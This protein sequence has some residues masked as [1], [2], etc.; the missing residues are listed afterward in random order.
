VHQSYDRLTYNIARD[1]GLYGADI[2][3]HTLNMAI[4]GL[5]PTRLTTIGGRSG[6]GKTSLVAQM[7]DAG[8]K[9]VNGRRCE[10]LFNTWELDPSLIIDRLICN[11]AGVNLRMLNQGAK[12]LDR[13]TL[14]RINGAYR[15]AE[16][17]P[18]FYQTVSTDIK[19]VRSLALEFCKRCKE[20]SVVEG[21]EIQPVGVVDYLNM[22]MFEG[23]GL[24]TYGIGDFMNG[25][26]QL[27]NET[28]MAWV[29][30]AQIS[31][32]TD[33]ENRIPDRADFS[34]SAAIENASDNLIVLYRPEYHGI[35]TIRNPENDMDEDSRNKMLVRILKCRDYGPGEVLMNC[36]VQYFRFWAHEHKWGHNYAQEYN[37]EQFWIQKFG[38]GQAHATVK[39]QI[40]FGELE[41][42]PF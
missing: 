33:K 13:I 4:G 1:W 20:K 28:G 8:S 41:D 38:L 31:R 40:Q 7:F 21:V 23:S 14:E 16:G 27:A 9:V 17:L 22:A 35:P 18:V 24:R 32:T 11:K 42:A 30:L 29:V 3:L 26:K 15:S 12:L 37:Q 5:I 19:T 10:F 2:G 25:L 6:T 34:D 36:D 39:D